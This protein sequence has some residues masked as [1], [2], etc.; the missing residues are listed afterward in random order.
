MRRARA[1]G[2]AVTAE[3]TPHHFSL[4]DGAAGIFVVQQVSGIGA[5]MSQSLTIADN[6]VVNGNQ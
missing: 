1:D 2:L 3:A 5:N 4:T 6:L